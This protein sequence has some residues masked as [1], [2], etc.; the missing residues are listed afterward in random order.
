MKL[1]FDIEYRTR[2]GEQLVLL[3]GKRKLAMR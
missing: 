1:V 2:W 3:L